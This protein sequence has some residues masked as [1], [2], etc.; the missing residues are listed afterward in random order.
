V[1]NRV[2]RVGCLSGDAKANDTRA[3]QRSMALLNSDCQDEID[4]KV[5][6]SSRWMRSSC[7]RRGRPLLQH[8]FRPTAI[9]AANRL[10]G[11]F[12]TQ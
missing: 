11:T 5:Q 12:G 2:R 6:A 10:R 1:T 7:S 8:G 3:S 9:I 4:V